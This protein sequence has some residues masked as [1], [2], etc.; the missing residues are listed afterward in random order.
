MNVDFGTVKNTALLVLVAVV[1]VGLIL[2][3]VIKKI[4]GKVIT[5]AI[6]AVVVFVGW[7]QREKV[8]D[9]YATAKTSATD[10]VC[11]THPSFFG[12]DVTFPGC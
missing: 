5:L 1:V 9:F 2:A 3:V 11:G 8:V 7:Q 6:A 12:V 4:V 10:T